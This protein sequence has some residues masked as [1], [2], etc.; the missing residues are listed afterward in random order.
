MSTWDDEVAEELVAA[1]RAFPALHSCHEAYAV[2]VEEIREVEA[3]VFTNHRQRDPV[4]LHR[5]LVQVAAMARRFAED[6]VE[7][8]L[9][10]T[11]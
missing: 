9:A 1:R 5:E 2:L 4:A 6:V 3:I 10:V 11:T 8:G 7:A